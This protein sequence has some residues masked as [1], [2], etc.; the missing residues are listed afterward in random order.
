MELYISSFQK[1]VKEPGEDFRSIVSGILQQKGQVHISITPTITKEEL[2][3][4]NQF[5]KN[6]KFSHLAEIIDNR[7]YSNYKLFKTN[8]IAFDILNNSDRFAEYYSK[9]EKNSFIEYI[10]TGLSKLPC[11]KDE[12]SRELENIILNIY[13]NPVNNKMKVEK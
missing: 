5:E 8:Y 12:A 9:E 6:D 3:F 13:A 1:Y 2:E 7:I 10:R 4:C 11:Y